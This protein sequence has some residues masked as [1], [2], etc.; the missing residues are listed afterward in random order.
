MVVRVS[1]ITGFTAKPEAQ[2]ALC[3]M[4]GGLLLQPGCARKLPGRTGR[5]PWAWQSQE[6]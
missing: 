4:T 6:D 1:N 2:V 3:S 5:F